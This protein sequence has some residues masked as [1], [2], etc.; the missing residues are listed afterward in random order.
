MT[1]IRCKMA[2]SRAALAS[3]NNV[4]LIEYK[5]LDKFSASSAFFARRVAAASNLGLILTNL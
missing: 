2:K 3:Y 1:S 5:M 4:L